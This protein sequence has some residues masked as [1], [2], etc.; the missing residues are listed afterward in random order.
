[1]SCN[2]LCF[3]VIKKLELCYFYNVKQIFILQLSLY[4]K[5]TMGFFCNFQMPREN[6]DPEEARH[7]KNLILKVIWEYYITENRND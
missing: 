4:L 3:T 7:D 1:M 6:N 2:H 5:I